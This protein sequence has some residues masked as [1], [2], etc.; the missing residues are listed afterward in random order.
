MKHIIAYAS[1]S[2]SD[3]ERR[4]SQTEKE[5]LAIVWS[6]E[7]FHLYIYGHPFVLVT[8]HKALEIIWNNPRSKPPARI[9]RWGLRLQPYNFKVEYRKGADNPADFMSRH[10]LPSHE[11]ESTRASKVAEEYVN[12][13]SFHSTPKAM[14]L[15]E[16]KTETLKDP[17]LQEAINHVTNNTWHQIE[18]SRNAETLKHFKHVR[19]ELTASPASD[20]LLRDTRIVIPTALHEKAIRLAHE[21]HQGIVKTKALLRTKV[22]FPDIDRKAEA[23]VRNCLACQANT[24]VTQNEPLK[25]SPLPEAPWHS[26]SA[27]FYGP[28]PSGEY[29][30]VITDDYSRYPVVEIVRSTSAVTVIPVMDKV[31]SMFGIPRVVKTDN[32]PP[33]N[34]VSFT[35]FAEYLGFHHRKITPLWPQANAT[36]ER[37]MRTLGKALR[38]AET[39]EEEKKREE[40]KEGKREE[41]E[42]KEGEREERGKIKWRRKRWR[43]RE[44]REKKERGGG[45]E[46]GGRG[47]RREGRESRGGEEEGGEKGEKKE[48]GEKAEEE[49]KGGERKEKEREGEKAEEEKKGRKK[50]GRGGGGEKGGRGERK[51][52]EDKVEE[53]KKGEERKEVEA[54]EEKRRWSV[55]KKEKQR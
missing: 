8:D 22:W 54:E 24:P 2:L 28:L 37:F 36:A 41:E 46:K 1:R 13:F 35:Q 17:V 3:V 32:G 47:E 5:A 7:H 11:S 15:Q 30:L 48:R 31:F 21:G 52:R 25:M 53:E 55:S 18:T 20:I 29:L 43:R 38:V 9:E 10:P 45:G 34:S 26:V 40:R 49:K 4:Y 27:D 44:R 12:F 51:E 6:C 39:Q 14:T 23:A 50:G 42:R 33:F 16:I 19:N